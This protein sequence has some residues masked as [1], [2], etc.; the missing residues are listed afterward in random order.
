MEVYE[1]IKEYLHAFWTLTVDGV[2]GHLVAP[3][4]LLQC[5]SYRY[6][7][8]RKEAGWLPQPD[9]V[10][11]SSEHFSAAGNRTTIFRAFSYCVD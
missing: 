3:A 11:Q 7:L 6:P 8:D 10:L 2:N 4:A 1:E 9:W 5:N